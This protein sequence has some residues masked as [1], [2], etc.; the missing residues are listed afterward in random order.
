MYYVNPEPQP[1]IKSSL[2]LIWRLLS[3][4]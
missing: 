3:I 1:N 2:E 4:V